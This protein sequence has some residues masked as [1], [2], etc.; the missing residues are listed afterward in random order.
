MKQNL[1]GIRG[2]DMKEFLLINQLYI[3]ERLSQTKILELIKKGHTLKKAKDDVESNDDFFTLSG[4]SCY[5]HIAT[6]FAKTKEAAYET[7]KKEALMT[8]GTEEFY[9]LKEQLEFIELA[10]KDKSD[11][12]FVV[13][14]SM[15]NAHDFGLL[16]QKELTFEEALQ[17]IKDDIP[18]ELF[19][20]G[21][22]E[23]LEH[24]NENLE[25]EI[26]HRFYR[27]VLKNT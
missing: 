10:S 12:Y 7:Y 26:G 4:D 23:E 8:S 20:S 5:E 19:D 9:F 13:Y 24:L 27:I 3:G 14:N 18:K 25:A 15:D 16:T 2:K 6:I 17:E 22:K 1:W 21:I 11:K